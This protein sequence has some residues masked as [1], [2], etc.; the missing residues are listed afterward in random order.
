[1]MLRLALAFSLALSIAACGTK[2]P[3]LTPSGDKTPKTQKD[4]SLPPNP[5]TR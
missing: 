3:L 4:P 2:S 1:M 5:I